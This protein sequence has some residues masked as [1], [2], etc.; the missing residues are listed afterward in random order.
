MVSRPKL[1]IAAV[2][3][4]GLAAAWVAGVPGLLSWQALAAHQTAWH[5][6][7]AAHPAATALLYVAGYAVVAGASIPAGG[8]LTITGGLLFGAAAGAAL[9]VT[10]ASLGAIMLF[11]LA[12]GTL[13]RLLAA[14]AQ[15]WLDRWRPTLQ[16]DGFWGLL[17]MRLLPAVPF[18]LGNLAPALLGMRLAPFAA[19]T[20]IGIIPATAVLAWLGAGLGTVLAAGQ[21]PDLSLLT[22]PAVLAPLAGLAALSLLPVVLRRWRREP[23]GAG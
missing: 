12:R 19:A 8:V 15:P 14:R 13:G 11:L 16:R 6:W 3:L 18:W 20:I 4:A 7:V 22:S 21:R 9:A 23:H 1:M 10:G 5:G 2:L 17:A